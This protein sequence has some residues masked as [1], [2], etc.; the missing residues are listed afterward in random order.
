MKGFRLTLQRMEVHT[1]A[2]N[3]SAS[4]YTQTCYNIIP[5][6]IVQQGEF[7]VAVTYYPKTVTN[8]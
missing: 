7:Y 1:E 4:C 6:F 5:L 3:C 8:M 2:G